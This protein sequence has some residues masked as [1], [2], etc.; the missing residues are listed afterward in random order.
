[1]LDNPFFPVLTIKTYSVKFLLDVMISDR[2]CLT[3][4]QIQWNCELLGGFQE[5]VQQRE[6]DYNKI[7]CADILKLNP[8]DLERVKTSSVHYCV[9]HYLNQI[10]NSTSHAT[11]VESIDFLTL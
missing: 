9:S 4:I 8:Y 3:S 1:M 11:V 7:D 6:I 10:E 5:L 2:W